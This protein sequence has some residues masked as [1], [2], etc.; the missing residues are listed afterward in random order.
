MIQHLV[1]LAS[2]ANRTAWLTPATTDQVIS[3]AIS[4]NAPLAFFK[5]AA[6][7]NGTMTLMGCSGNFSR[8]RRSGTCRSS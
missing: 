4:P 1:R 2:S 3:P 6:D 8:A 7:A 5:P